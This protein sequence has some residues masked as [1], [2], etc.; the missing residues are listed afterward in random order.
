MTQD[1]FPIKQVIKILEVQSKNWNSPVFELIKVREQNVFKILISTIISLR[2]KDEVTI[3]SSKRLFKI[4]QKPEDIQNI[5]TKDIQN[6]IYPCGFYKRKAIQIEIIC[7]Q[8]VIHF[9]STIPND[10]ET[11]L[12]FKGVGRKTANLVLSEGF[13]IPAICVD[14]HVHRIS[15][16]LGFIQT[17]TPLETEL[18]LIKN[19]PKQYWNIYNTI[20]VAFGQKLCTPINPFCSKCPVEIYCNKIDV[21]KEKSR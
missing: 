21:N 11:L 13:N 18:E 12:S 3:E 10:I 4:L 5:S 20:L 15:N 2:T 19:L 17:K 9:N 14:V 16:R 1:N 6:A 7:K 8:L